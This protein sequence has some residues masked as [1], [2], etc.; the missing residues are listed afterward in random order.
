MELIPVQKGFCRAILNKC[1]SVRRPTTKFVPKQRNVEQTRTPVKNCIRTTFWYF[2][3]GRTCLGSFLRVIRCGRTVT[4]WYYL[5]NIDLKNKLRPKEVAQFESR[6][7]VPLAA[8]LT[9][10]KSF[11]T[12]SYGPAPRSQRSI[13]KRGPLQRKDRRLSHNKSW[14]FIHN[15]APTHTSLFV[16]QFLQRTQILRIAPTSVFIGLSPLQFFLSPKLMESL[17]GKSFDTTKRSR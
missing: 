1:L 15:S 17:K 8:F 5:R 4:L 3:K 11:I 13:I 12:S 2:W 7:K 9:V 10:R 14:V 16:Q 6:A